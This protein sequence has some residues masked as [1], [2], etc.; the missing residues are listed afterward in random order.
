VAKREMQERYKNAQEIAQ[1]TRKRTERE[2][3]DEQKGRSLSGKKEI[4]FIGRW[5]LK[6]GLD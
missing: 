6:R 3:I 5:G 1:K 2:R 4:A